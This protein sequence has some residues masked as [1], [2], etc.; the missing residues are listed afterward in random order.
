VELGDLEICNR[1]REVVVGMC[2]DVA[3]SEV[4]FRRRYWCRSGT[5]DRALWEGSAGQLRREQKVRKVLSGVAKSHGDGVFASADAFCCR[6]GGREGFES[7]LARVNLLGAAAR[8]CP[9]RWRLTT[10][11]GWVEWW[12]RV[13]WAGVDAD[14]WWWAVGSGSQPSEEARSRRFGLSLVFL[15]FLSRFQGPADAAV[16]RPRL[17]RNASMTKEW[18]EVGMVLDNAR[19]NKALPRE[20]S[21]RVDWAQWVRPGGDLVM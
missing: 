9:G 14:R 3:V 8:C 2:G 19:N 12:C 10:S 1:L 6:S 18:V 17:G 16:A 4:F 15:P 20:R 7:L 13:W 21:L 5:V 11:G